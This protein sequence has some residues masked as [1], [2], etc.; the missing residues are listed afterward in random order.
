MAENALFRIQKLQRECSGSKKFFLL[1]SGNF[2]KLTTVY[3][4]GRLRRVSVQVLDDHDI[5]N[6]C[7]KIDKACFIDPFH[8]HTSIYV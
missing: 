2:N 1:I 8:C 3:N 7:F 4:Y 5:F 6:K